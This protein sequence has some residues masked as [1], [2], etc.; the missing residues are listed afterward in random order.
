MPT[1]PLFGRVRILHDPAPLCPIP[2]FRLLH[3][4]LRP[5]AH[6]WLLHKVPHRAFCQI[7]LRNSKQ[8]MRSPHKC[9]G[10]C[11]VVSCRAA[12]WGGTSSQIF[13]INPSCLLSPRHPQVPLVAHS[14]ATAPEQTGF[15]FGLLPD[16]TLSGV[17]TISHFCTLSCRAS[18]NWHLEVCI[19]I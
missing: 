4:T 18:R 2:I 7:T 13:Q 5:P 6:T 12:L 16:P 19:N 3:G 8:S 14:A 17:A 11:S 1:A 10:D 9:L 15:S